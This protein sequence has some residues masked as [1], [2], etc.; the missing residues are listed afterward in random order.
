MYRRVYGRVLTSAVAGQPV[1]VRLGSAEFVVARET[2]PQWLGRLAGQHPLLVG[3]RPAHHHTALPV[4]QGGRGLVSSG[5][6]RSRTVC[7]TNTSLY[8]TVLY[9]LILSA[10]QSDSDNG[11]FPGY[12]VELRSR[13]TRVGKMPA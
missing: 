10:Q 8:C 2:D 11:S 9:C 12:N 6:L 3:A 13:Q 7:H 1:V 5:Q 4:T